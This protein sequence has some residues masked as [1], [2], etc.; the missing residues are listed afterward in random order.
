[1]IIHNKFWMTWGNQTDYVFGDYVF[2][3]LLHPHVAALP[4]MTILESQTSGRMGCGGEW[5][6]S[7]G[8]YIGDEC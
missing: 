1:M 2:G 3:N 7:Q 6:W 5:R 4:A 8:I